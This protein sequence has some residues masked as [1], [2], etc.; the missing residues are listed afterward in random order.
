MT[1][2]EEPIRSSDLAGMVVLGLMMFCSNIFLK[3][4]HGFCSPVMIFIMKL[5]DR[6]G[7]KFSLSLSNLSENLRGAF[8]PE[9][10][11]KP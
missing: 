4:S 9:I 10:V 3:S 7:P 6:F 8:I 1:G 5:T 11:V 2:K